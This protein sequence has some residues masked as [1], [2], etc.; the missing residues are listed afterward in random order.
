M[1]GLFG[2]EIAPQAERGAK[3]DRLFLPR[4]V[5][6]LARSRILDDDAVA[7]AHAIVVRWADL[8]K[9]G[10]LASMNESQLEGD[11]VRE[12]F[13]DALH[14]IRKTENTE[15]WHFESKRSC[16]GLIPDAVIGHFSSKAPSHPKVVVELKGPAVNLDRDRSAGRTPVRQLWDYL[17]EI[18]EAQ[19]GI[20]TNIVSFRLYERNHTPRRYEH[21]TLQGLRDINE[22]RRFYALFER[23]GLIDARIGRP[24][25]AIS[26]LD[27]TDSEQREVSDRLYEYYSRERMELIH[28][29][30][31]QQGLSLQD[32]IT[33]AQQLLDRVIFIAFCEDRGLLPEKTL[34]RAWS[35]LPPFEKATNPR[36]RNFLRLFRAV[37]EGAPDLDLAEGYNGGLF[38]ESIV[39]SLDLDD[40]WARFLKNIGDYDFRDE[41]NLDVLGHLFERSITELEKLRQGDFFGN[42]ANGKQQYAQMPKSAKRKRLGVYYTPPQLT[43]LIAQITL[44]DLIDRRMRDLAEERHAGQQKAAASHDYWADAL[45][46][47][48]AI[49]VCDPACGSGAFLFQAYEILESRY[50]EIIAHLVEHDPKAAALQD[51]IPDLILTENLYGVDY[52][53]EAVEIARLA[54]WIRS[55][56][57]GRKLTDLSHNIRT[58]NSLVDDPSVDP[59]AFRWHEE[60]PEVFDRKE[61]GFDCIIGNPPWERIKLQEREFFALS[62]PHI[63]TATD[64][65][66]RRRRIEEL[67]S[68]NPELYRRYLEAK[69]AAERL[70]DFVRNSGK[71]PLTGKGDI[72]TYAV[73]AELASQLVAPHGRVGLLVPS[74]IVSDKTTKDFFTS[75]VESCRLRTVRDFEN[76]KG[77][78]PD[79][80]RSFKFCILSFGG[81]AEKTDD[82]EF[83]FYLHTVDEI[84]QRNR[85]ITLTSDDLAR[86][87]PNTRTCPVFR[88]RQDAQIT[89]DIYRH[90]PVLWRRDRDD[91]NPW[92]VKF[93]RMFDQTNDA[94]HFRDEASLRRGRFR[95]DGR[96]WR[97]GRRTMLPLY[98]AK[99]IQAYD[100][101]A[102]GVVV[103]DRNW[104][105]QGQ[106]RPTAPVDHQ[107]PEFFP[108]PRFW[109]D[110]QECRARLADEPAPAYIAFKDITS[111]TNQR[112]MIAAFIPY[113]G[114]MNSAPLILC[115]DKIPYTKRAAL[116]ANMNSVA[117]DFCAR[118]KVGNVHLNYFI[119]EQLP[120]L[121]PHAY[122]RPCPW[123][124]KESLADWIATRVFK[125][126]CTAR[127]MLPLADAVGFRE[128]D[129]EGGRLNRWKEDERARLTAELD[130]AY[131]H[132]YA[133]AREDAEH[134]LSTFQGLHTPASDIPGIRSQAE[135]ILDAYDR[136][137]AHTR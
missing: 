112:T 79:V 114:V 23:H 116:L 111:P 27:E 2:E 109:V 8:E 117:Y 9:T 24:P 55:A 15:Q 127:D 102:A 78:F 105:R 131:L 64:A 47:L 61:S 5:D 53:A 93:L 16:A 69:Q 28:Y 126:T 100:H 29:L 113:S 12:I 115:D 95:R 44:D 20:I 88:T 89:R 137:A 45:E 18:P 25:R 14:Y 77:L 11:F 71:Y 135:E 130:A 21:F 128:G 98:E 123:H 94:E 36:W 86:L 119:I 3:T 17:N 7:E 62:A 96:L 59:L 132:L 70:L 43:S 73:F 121:P 63:A 118:Q 54:L 57:P 103:E 1:A 83:S 40:R 99:M 129:L 26:L 134:I 35:T 124:P 37:D 30:F 33:A 76:K 81:S 66:T 104:M 56:R 75:L 46:T 31:Y 65:A 85:R 38:A 41:I 51:R 120:T 92:G 125:L 110:E 34:E 13:G 107:D 87:N 90:V 67:Q 136:L 10:R 48:K 4:A 19:W 49:K 42:G 60:F 133:V 50:T 82:I 72:N 22:F 6:K 52:S 68:Q 58:G 39:D 108:E 101:R 97:K 32:S 106:T 91:G 122:D 74:G 80:H 84:Q